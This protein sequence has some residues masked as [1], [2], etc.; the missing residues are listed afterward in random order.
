MNYTVEEMLAVWLSHTF[1]DGEVGF[2][3]LA[4]GKAAATYI[5][6][7]PLAAMELA[8]RTH[9]PNL[10]VLLCGWCVNPHLEL[11][12]SMPESEYDSALLDL[13]CEGHMTMWPG[14][15]SHHRGEI[16]FAFGSGVQVDVRGNMNSTRIGTPDKTKVA[17]V[18][19]IFLPE[20]MAIFG[21]E[22]IMMPHHERRSFV[23]AVDHITGVGFP[24]GREG[25]KA[26]GLTGDGP[27]A[28][29]TPKCIFGF[30]ETGHIYVESIHPGVTAEELQENTGFDLGDLSAVPVTPAPTEEELTILRTQVDPKGVLLG[31]GE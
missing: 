3:G 23:Q 12:D 27:R 1:K 25:R 15:W 8:K 7:I 13:P 17:L 14:P 19:P 10:T 28:V 16:S 29:C 2:T 4:T 31:K 21:R 20:H 11:L 6:N 26:L 9:A 24:T 18:G 22:Y 5:T 30:D